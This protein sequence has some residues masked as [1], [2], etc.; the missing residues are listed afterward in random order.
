[1]KDRTVPLLILFALIIAGVYWFTRSRSPHKPPAF[2]PVSIQTQSPPAVVIMPVSTAAVPANVSSENSKVEINAESSSVTPPAPE[3]P[4][5]EDELIIR[6][7]DNTTMKRVAA[8]MDEHDISIIRQVDKLGMARVKIPAGM[9]LPEAEKLLKEIGD[10]EHTERNIRTEMP[11]E[12][13]ELPMLGP[14]QPMTAVLQDGK[15]LIAI[16]DAQERASYG[17]NVRIALL[18]TGVDGTHP[19]LVDRVIGGYNFVDD[20]ADV[21]DQNGHGTACAGILVGTGRGADTVG[22]IA[23]QAYLIPIKVMN[24][25]GKGESF[26]VIEGLVYAVDQGAKVINLSIGTKST[27]SALKEAIDYVL[28]KGAIVVGAAGNDG[29]TDILKPGAY[30]EVICVGAVDGTRQY[31]PFSNYGEEIDIVAPGVAIYTTAPDGRYMQ[32]SGTS[33]AAPFVSGALAALISENPYMSAEEITTKLL[34]GAD[35][36]GYA[37]HDEY[38]GE[39]MLNLKRSLISKADT[40]YDGALTALYFSPN[41]LIPGQP[42]EIHFVLENQGNEPVSGAVFTYMIGDERHEERVDSLKPGECYDV[43][44]PWTI[45]A[46]IPDNPITIQGYLRIDRADAEPDDNGKGVSISLSDWH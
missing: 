14:G 20:T 37:G 10:V 3:L 6:I 35:N 7:S 33:S 8:L 40:V 38:F 16:G 11:K 13:R 45:P 2:S 41:E 1:M 46:E 18:D 26:A 22:G 17:N 39:G 12:I 24:D 19:D 43:T 29:S 15:E 25:A 27:S 30:P 28:S 9:S 4:W 34:E 32:F 31:A 21:S 44:A 23:P 5:L 42:T 36:L